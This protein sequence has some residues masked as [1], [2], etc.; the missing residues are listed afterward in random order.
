MN[1][2]AWASGHKCLVGLNNIFNL[3]LNKKLLFFL[4]SISYEFS[5]NV[6]K[7][8]RRDL[9]LFN[10]FVY[11]IIFLFIKSNSILFNLV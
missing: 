10:I 7:T 2:I 6:I 11:L 8:M 3:F 1:G 5:L 9:F 4:F